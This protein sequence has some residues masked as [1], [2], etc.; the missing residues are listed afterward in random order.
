MVVRIE[1]EGATMV[2]E[3][4]ATHEQGVPI[5]SEP[6]PPPTLDKGY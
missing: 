2:A 4:T 6:P 1:K 5:G 3:T